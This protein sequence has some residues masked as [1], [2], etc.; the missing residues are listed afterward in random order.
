MPTSL[1]LHRPAVGEIDQ[2]VV[3]VVDDVVVGQDVAVGADDDPRAE[4]ALLR[5]ANALARPAWSRPN[6]IAEE[7]AEQVFVIRPANR[8]GETRARP[9]VLIVTT[10][11]ATILTMSAYES[12]PPADG[13]ACRRPVRRALRD[14]C[15]RAQRGRDRSPCRSR[16]RREQSAPRPRRP[17]RS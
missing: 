3:G 17:A 8:V 10:A 4:T 13:G 15:L 5:A 12:R 6:L 11:G 9:S 14:G 1:A 2:D 7:P 16:W